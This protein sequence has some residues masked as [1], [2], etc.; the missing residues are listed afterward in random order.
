MVAGSKIVQ[1][2]G[3]LSFAYIV[4]LEVG[5]LIFENILLVVCGERAQSLD[6]FGTSNM[7]GW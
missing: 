2:T 5:N 1:Y 6:E 7:G 4:E 3:K